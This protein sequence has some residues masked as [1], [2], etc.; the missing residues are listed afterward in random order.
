MAAEPE[1]IAARV[2]TTVAEEWEC[3]L[4]RVG[5]SQSDCAF[6]RGAFVYE[7]LELPA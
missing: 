6:V 2:F 7:G 5:V 1:A 4:R 3:L